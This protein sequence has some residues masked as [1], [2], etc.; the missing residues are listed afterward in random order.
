MRYTT[1]SYYYGN[2]V[3]A[4]LLPYIEQGNIGNKWRY[5]NPPFSSVD[6]TGDPWADKDSMTASVI[7]TFVCPSDKLSENPFLLN[8]NANSGYAQ[9]WYGA[10]SYLGNCGTHST[11]FGDPQMSADGIFFM[12]GPQS[13]P[14]ANQNAVAIGAISDGT[15]NTLMFGERNH[16]DPVFD[17][18]M[19]PPNATWSRYPI[20]KWAAWGWTTGGNGTTH[21]LGSTSTRIN[22]LTPANVTPGY[23]AVN[24]R[25]RAYGSGHSGGASFCLTD[26]SV[27]FIK[28]SI[29]DTTLQRLVHVPTAK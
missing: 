27:R 22:Y 12:T 13:K 6:S 28:D 5:D 16:W 4:Y 21:V 25:M 20:R 24:T 19:A 15:S 10:T 2:T 14:R 7:S 29:A 9:G 11:Y 3:F 23:A 26:G 17:A 1:G 8:Y 18:K